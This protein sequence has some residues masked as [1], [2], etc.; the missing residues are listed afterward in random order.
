MARTLIIGSSDGLGL[1]LARRLDAA[2]H[3]VV[4]T[5]MGG[6]GGAGNVV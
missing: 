3:E 1:E 5:K 2:C 4:L 6:A